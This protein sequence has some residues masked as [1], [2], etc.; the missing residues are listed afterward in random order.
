MNFSPFTVQ[1]EFLSLVKTVP[2]WWEWKT[3]HENYII[4]TL[5]STSMHAFAT[6][7]W[8]LGGNKLITTSTWKRF[9]QHKL[10]RKQ[11]VCNFFCCKYNLAALNWLSKENVKL[12]TCE[13]YIKSFSESVT[14]S[15]TAVALAM[16]SVI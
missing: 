12:S 1:S 13:I 2:G 9:S 7:R 11:H 10:I 14:S 8:Q 4:Q 16:S 3:L 6:V 15:C 5:D